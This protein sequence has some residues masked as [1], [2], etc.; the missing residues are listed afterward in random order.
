[1]REHKDRRDMRDRRDADGRLHVIREDQ[2]RA[3][4]GDHPAV[5]VQAIQR[6][7]HRMLAHAKTQVASCRVILLEIASFLELR[8]VGRRQVCRTADELG[9][10]PGYGIQYFSGGGTRGHP[11]GIDREGRQ[12]DIPV[13]R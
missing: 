7:A 9:K 8:I 4:I 3:A 1:V 2:E 12:V 10:L 13:F 5:Q 11:F 6:G